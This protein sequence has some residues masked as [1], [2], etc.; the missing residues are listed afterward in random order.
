[1]I[2]RLASAILWL[3]CT[4]GAIGWVA[5]MGDVLEFWRLPL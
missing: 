5:A 2:H 1:V 3:V 4:I